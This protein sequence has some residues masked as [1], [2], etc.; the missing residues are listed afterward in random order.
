MVGI[1]GTS[2]QSQERVSAQV[3][4][5]GPVAGLRALFTETTA[6]S[7]AT[8]EEID[9]NREAFRIYR[10]WALSGFLIAATMVVDSTGRDDQ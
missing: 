4:G 10:G 9:F 6:A 3:V 2:H 7:S 8:F 5:R 1:F